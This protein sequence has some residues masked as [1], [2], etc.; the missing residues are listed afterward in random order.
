VRADQV[1]VADPAVVD[2][3]AGLHRGLQ[4]LDH[5]AFL[6]QVVLDLDAGDFLEGLGQNLG[7]VLVGGDG[8]GDDRIS[9]TPL[10]FS[11]AARR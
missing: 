10:A 3:L 7:F 8:F 9:L 1:G 4:L 6:D 2:R 5:V 11:L